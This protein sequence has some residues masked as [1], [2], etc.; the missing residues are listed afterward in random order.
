MLKHRIFVT[1]A[2]IIILATFVCPA[3]CLAEASEVIF[4][5]NTTVQVSRVNI[6][7]TNL[8]PVTNPSSSLSTIAVDS[9]DAS[10]FLSEE[11]FG[12]INS[13]DFDGSNLAF[14]YSGINNPTSISLDPVAQYIYWIS[15]TSKPTIERIA[16]SSGTVETIFPNS[17]G[18][19]LLRAISVDGPGGYIYWSDHTDSSIWRANLDGSS[20]AKL[21]TTSDNDVYGIS[22]DRLNGWIYWSERN[23]G[24]INRA[25]L[26]GNT[27][28]SVVTGLSSPMGISVD[29]LKDD[30][31][32]IYIG[33]NGSGLYLYNKSSNG[34]MQMLGSS[35]SVFA[36]VSVALRYS[37]SLSPG[38]QLN[39]PPA[40]S[41]NTSN[42][43]VTFT[44]ED[45]SDVTQTTSKSSLS[46]KKTTQAVWDVTVISAQAS[47][48][49][50]NSTSRRY[51]KISRNNR[52]T[53]K[54]PPGT[55]TA[56]YNVKLVQTKPKAK[57]RARR[58]RLNER[59]ASLKDRK[60]STSNSSKKTTI[61]NR[62][63]DTNAQKKLA[64][65]KIVGTST[66][67]PSSS[68]FTIN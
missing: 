14:L 68:S 62:I 4:Y 12:E 45:F 11:V 24:V 31:S 44:M 59:I 33:T 29:P 9:L 37:K 49:A 8:T 42:R 54:L 64:G 21:I 25:T 28:E 18:L 53:L 65:F 61:S 60:K 41:I 13:V 5:D 55:Y 52:A 3:L 51:R 56:S 43:K 30:T 19:S 46:T 15:N 16:Y 17:S 50:S 1:Y 22:V 26:D 58:E 67:S 47:E 27:I 66:T 23:N 7:G 32:K 38:F 10:I 48:S 36:P 35:D 6:D 2:A 63:V 20:S 57:A 40:V 39:S 34:L